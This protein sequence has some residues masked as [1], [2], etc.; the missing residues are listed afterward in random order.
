MTQT[1]RSLSVQTTSELKH[2]ALP[3]EKWKIDNRPPLSIRINAIENVAVCGT[4]DRTNWT[5]VARQSINRSLSN[6]R[7]RGA[8][9]RATQESRDH[10][11]ADESG[12]ANKH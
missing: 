10:S 12:D 4:R 9:A 6:S 5:A 8:G 3:R 2:P 1:Y 7:E 11:R